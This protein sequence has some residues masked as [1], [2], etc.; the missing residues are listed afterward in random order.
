[1][2]KGS[3]PAFRRVRKTTAVDSVL[4]QIKDYVRD[5]RSAAGSRLPSER[6]LARTLGVSRPTLREALR[7]LALI[8]VVSTRHGS[9][10]EL[11]ASGSNVLRTPLQFLLMLDQPSVTDLHET[12]ELIDV[13]LAGR[14]AQRRT[15][16]DLRA[17]QAPLHDLK[18]AMDRR[19]GYTEPDFRFHKSLWAAAHHPIL[20]RVM[21][22]L[23]ENIVE[24]MDVVRPDVHDFTSSYEIHEKIYDAI[25]RRNARRARREMAVHHEWMTDELR[26]A[27]LIP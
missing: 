1:M 21:S 2:V 27:K 22:G 3:S 6:E 4:E 13:F 14:A 11:A 12:R 24:L 5:N 7:T 23:Q 17:M 9:G 10:T 16:E 19:E 26:H 20:E 15:P 25:R 8:G 18:A